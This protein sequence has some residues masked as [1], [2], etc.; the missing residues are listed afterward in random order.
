MYE[1][2]ETLEAMND[3]RKCPCGKTNIFY[4]VNEARKQVVILRILHSL[5]DWVHQLRR[6]KRYHYVK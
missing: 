5:Q 6:N 1:I 2:R 4:V 3:L